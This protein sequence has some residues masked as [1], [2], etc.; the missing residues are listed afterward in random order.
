MDQTILVN[1]QIAEGKQLL[2]RLREAGFPVT[3]AGWIWESERSQWYLYVVSPIVEDEGRGIAYRRIHAVVRQMPQ[4]FSIEPLDVMAVGLHQ[5][6]GEAMLD[7]YRRQPGR[8]S[9]RLGNTRF[10]DVEIEGAYIYPPV[11][12]ADQTDGQRSGVK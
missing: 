1:E 9:Y 12:V 3:A 7:L 5:P 8:S 4:G 10:G 11:A 6:L 2:D